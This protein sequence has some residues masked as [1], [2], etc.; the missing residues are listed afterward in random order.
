MSYRKLNINGE[1]WNYVIGTK[2]VKI[3]S[4][5]NKSTW[6]EKYKILDIPEEDYL[7]WVKELHDDDYDGPI[8]IAVGPGNV[9]NYIVKN[10]K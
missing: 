8:A 9:K 7:I 1:I 4:P 5:Q 6:I 2:G 3:K 10:L